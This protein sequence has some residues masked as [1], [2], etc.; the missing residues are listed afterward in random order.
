[1]ISFAFWTGKHIQSSSVILPWAT[2]SI[3]SE[4]YMY[5]FCTLQ[6]VHT[7]NNLKHT[8]PFIQ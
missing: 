2:I 8:N 3:Q 5:I 7:H 1:M 4:R 6:V